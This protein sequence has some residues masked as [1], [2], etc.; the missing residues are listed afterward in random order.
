MSRFATP[1]R[2][3]L[4]A[5]TAALALA[6]APEG[7]LAADKVYL[8]DG[9]VFEGTITREDNG[10]IW[11]K[12][13]GGVETFFRPGDIDRVERDAKPAE[14]AGA[15][16]AAPAAK[17]DPRARARGAGVPRIAILSLGEP[18]GQEMVGLYITAQSLRD[19][20]PILEKEGVTD[21]VFKINS[22][23]GLALEMPKV[24]DVIHYE[25]KPKFRTVAWIESAISAAAMLSHCIE[26]IYFMPRGNYGACTAWSG[27]LVAVKE[28]P[29]EEIL[30]DMEK[31]SARGGYDPKIMRSM[32]VDDPLSCTIDEKTGDVTWFQDESGQYIVNP[33]GQILTFNAEQALKYKFSKGTAETHEELARLMGYTEVEFVG[34]PKPGYSW[35]ISDA[36]EFLRSFRQRTYTDEKNLVLYFNSYQSAVQTAQ[37]M[38]DRRDRAKFVGRARQF[39]D[40]IEAMVRN[41]ENM[42]I[43]IGIGPEDFK[44]W[45]EEQ[46]EL[47]RRLL[48]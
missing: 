23:G 9:R 41:N 6:L 4:L 14:P 36:D 25:Y 18:P 11:M 48:R 17:A 22:G 46:R 10:Y 31:I 7:A 34:K 15:A 43:M 19:A 39:L 28:R 29:L 37:S 12:V 42:A 27:A 30:F 21:V 38:Q 13:G 24:S 16:A 40:K 44:K 33:K 20:I 3:A 32:Q 2:A 26:E 8:K 35:P 47:L 5:L 45:V 1:V